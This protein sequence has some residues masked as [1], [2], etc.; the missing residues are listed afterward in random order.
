MFFFAKAW[1]F[2]YPKISVIGSWTLRSYTKAT[3]GAVMEQARLIWSLGDLQRRAPVFF[4]LSI[5]PCF[6]GARK[7]GKCAT[8]QTM[9]QRFYQTYTS[10]MRTTVAVFS[11]QGI[12]KHW[13][14]SSPHGHFRISPPWQNQ[15]PPPCIELTTSCSKP[16]KRLSSPSSVSWVHEINLATNSTTEKCFCISFK[17]PCRIWEGA[18]EQTMTFQVFALASF[19]N[20]LS[21]LIY[22][23][24]VLFSATS[25]PIYAPLQK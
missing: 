1:L 8:F 15:L 10:A 13:V 12:S 22:Y 11:R 24:S 14:Y 18:A 3:K 25:S 7:K 4:S 20:T 9:P 21:I 19:K 23:C 16:P 2:S 17:V 6:D 5:L